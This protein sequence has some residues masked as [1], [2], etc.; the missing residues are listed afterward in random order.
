MPKLYKSKKNISMRS[1]K[2]KTHGHKNKILRG[3][4][5]PFTN[6]ASYSALRNNRTRSPTLKES[7][8]NP[9]GDV[10]KF[11]KKMKSAH[12]TNPQSYILTDK[13]ITEQNAMDEF[14]KVLKENYNKLL[15]RYK[16]IRNN[17]EKEWAEEFNSKW[18]GYRDDHPEWKGRTLSV[19]DYYNTPSNPDAL[20]I[21]IINKNTTDFI[22]ECNI[23]LEDYNTKVN[24]FQETNN[25]IYPYPYLDPKINLDSRYYNILDI[26]KDDDDHIY[27]YAYNILDINNNDDRT[28]AYKELNYIYGNN[29][30]N[31]KYGNK[32]L[33]FVLKAYKESQTPKLI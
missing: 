13:L 1:N 33:K 21:N 16:S 11:T 23:L 32:S 27:R 24:N 28:Y 14:Y 10:S 2:T 5:W 7:I 31:E 17:D 12:N 20:D 25:P 15:K 18:N 22:K 30:T 9:Y 3:G 6:T 4:V 29:F 19:S 26:N 8:K